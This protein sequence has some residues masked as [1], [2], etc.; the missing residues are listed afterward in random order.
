MERP[1]CFEHEQTKI[2]KYKASPAYS[3]GFLNSISV[4]ILYFPDFPKFLF[5]KVNQYG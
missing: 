3:F 4:L 1:R 5:S 2:A